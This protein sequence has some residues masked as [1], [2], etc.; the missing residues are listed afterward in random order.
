MRGSFT[1]AAVACRRE[2]SIPAF[3]LR[4]CSVIVVVF[5]CFGLLSFNCEREE[6]AFDCGGMFQMFEI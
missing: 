1:K 3:L 5:A 2:T 4:I 6:E